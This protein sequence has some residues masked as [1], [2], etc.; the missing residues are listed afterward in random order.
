FEA[1]RRAGWLTSDVEAVHI[2][3]GSVLGADGK[4]FKTRSGE[5]VRRMDLLDQAVAAAEQVV[6]EG[7][8]AKGS[9]LDEDS[10]QQIAE[11]AGIGAVKYADLSGS[12]VKDYVFD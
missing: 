7:A 9:E 12:R 3:V 4:P 1:A 6:R 8:E 2:S 10:L 11:Q 5:T